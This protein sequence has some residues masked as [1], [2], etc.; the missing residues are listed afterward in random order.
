MAI[1]ENDGHQRKS[2]SVE[3]AAVNRVRGKSR[4]IKSIGNT[5]T[6]HGVD[7][8]EVD[9]SEDSSAPFRRSHRLKPPSN[10]F[11]VK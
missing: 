10:I 4:V 3:K 5:H 8:C 9:F 6:K 1:K 11:E 2:W 7:R